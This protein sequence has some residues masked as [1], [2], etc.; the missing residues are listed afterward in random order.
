MTL[1]NIITLFRVVVLPLLFYLLSLQNSTATHVAL[2]LLVMAFFT[3]IVDGYVA[4]QRREVTKIGSFLD[5]FADKVL[6]LGLLVFFVVENEFPLLLLVY[7]IIMD[8]LSA[9]LRWIAARDD[10]LFPEKVYRKLVIYSQLGIVLGLLLTLTFPSSGFPGG[11]VILSTI[12]AVLSAFVSVCYY[13]FV[14]LKTLKTL[15]RMGRDITTEKMVILAN[16]KSGGYRSSYR[17]HLL[18]IFS[19][20]RH[21]PIMYLPQTADMYKGIEK[22]IKSIDH[23]VIAGGDGSFESALNHAALQKKSLGFF[24]FGKGNAFYSYFYRGKRF[25]YLRSRFSFQEADLDVIELEWDK[26]TRQTMFLSLGLDAEIVRF[27]MGRKDNGFLPYLKACVKGIQKAQASF[28][29]DLIVDGK[30]MTW[31]NCITFTL[32]KVPYYGFA[33]RSLFHVQPHDG[34]VYGLGHVNTHAAFFNKVLRLWTILLVNMGINKPPLIPLRGKVIEVR[35]EVPFPL[36]AGGEFVGFTQYM[37]VKVV[38]KQKVLV[39]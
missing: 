27:S 38:R 24:P 32:G 12:L 11:I 16:K 25:E 35:S 8:L 28:D 5:P 36:Q 4:R 15:R 13:S 37:K 39:I 2:F 17:R 21:A 19:R 26:G 31:D 29:L 6:V 18:G 20:R 33:V 10:V 34:F 22:K 7:F 9:A 3:D 1:A 14:Y 23:V 30:K